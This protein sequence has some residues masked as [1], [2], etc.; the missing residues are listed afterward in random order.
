[1]S[2]KGTSTDIVLYTCASALGGSILHARDTT[3]LNPHCHA[4]SV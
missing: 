2:A 1:M 4:S 3:M